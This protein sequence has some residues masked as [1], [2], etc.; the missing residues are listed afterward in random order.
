[1]PASEHSS[2]DSHG[3]DVPRIIESAHDPK[4]LKPAN[5]L[6]DL[7]FDFHYMGVH[8]WDRGNGHQ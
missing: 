4:N 8:D 6:D 1:M 3:P 5:V 7:S 2:T